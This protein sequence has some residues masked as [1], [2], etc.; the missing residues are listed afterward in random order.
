MSILEKDIERKS[1]DYA[2]SIGYISLK[3]NVVGQRGWPD[4]LFINPYGNHVWIEFKKLG[5]KLSKIQEHRLH[6]LWDKNT[7]AH[8]TDNYK[9][10]C[11][12]LDAAL[13]DNK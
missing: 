11:D 1:S 10:A 4:R 3:I 6:Q 7:E 12:I 2:E 8:Y 9:D 5:E 13:E